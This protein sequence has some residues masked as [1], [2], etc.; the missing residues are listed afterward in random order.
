MEFAVRRHEDG[1]LLYHSRVG[2]R[3]WCAFRSFTM[4]LELPC[5]HAPDHCF[6]CI[7]CA[8][9]QA[10]S[11]ASI[12]QRLAPGGRVMTNLGAAPAAAF[13]GRPAGPGIVTTRQALAAM[14]EAFDGERPM[15]QTLF[16]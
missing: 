13:A 9:T 6:C 2:V 10:A 3:C 15:R 12:R 14:A 4:F 5:Q 11:W 16:A 1:E 8:H 7:C